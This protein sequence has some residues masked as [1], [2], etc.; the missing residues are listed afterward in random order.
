MLLQSGDY[1]V[2]VE[3]SLELINKVLKYIEEKEK[4]I[5]GEWGSCRDFEELLEDN[6]VPDI[7]FE[8]KA[9]KE[10]EK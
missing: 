1:M 6:D 9:L 5:D 3:I 10:G 4:Q 2:K 7:Y 8:L